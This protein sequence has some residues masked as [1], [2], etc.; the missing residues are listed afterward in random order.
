MTTFW[1]LAALMLVVALLFVLPPLLR[2]RRQQG[3]ERGAL[4]TQ[5]IKDELA[6][7]EADLA[8]GKLSETDYAAARNDLERELLDSAAVDEVV[9]GD[10]RGG[11]WIGALLIILVPAA[12]VLIYQQIGN[13]FMIDRLAAAPTSQPQTDAQR[14][15]SMETV[16]PESAVASK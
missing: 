9:A 10:T 11:R 6:E 8:A 2:Q 7:L 4:N 1:S 16:C 13:Q 3:V 15:P 5:V 12:A 14:G